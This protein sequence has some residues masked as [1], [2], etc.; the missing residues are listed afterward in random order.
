[1]FIT[2]L[3]IKTRIPK[4]KKHEQFHIKTPFN[5]F[6][7]DDPVSHLLIHINNL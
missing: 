7:P 2:T 5:D 1:M 4:K 3:F 6:N